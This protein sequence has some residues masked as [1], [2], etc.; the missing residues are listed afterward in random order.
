MELDKEELPSVDFL[1]KEMR[2][3]SDQHLTYLSEKE[4]FEP[5]EE[6]IKPGF[7]I[8]DQEFWEETPKARILLEEAITKII[9]GNDAEY[10]KSFKLRK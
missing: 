6:D 10:K 5:F 7:T 4:I 1:A 2:Q 9:K 8:F 3:C